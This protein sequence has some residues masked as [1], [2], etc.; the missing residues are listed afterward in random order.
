MI[1]MIYIEASFSRAKTSLPRT[2]AL[3]T[4]LQIEQYFK[5][6]WTLI[7]L[8]DNDDEFDVVVFLYL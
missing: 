5:H 1:Y 2:I 8:F 6:L 3:V 4:R 7:A